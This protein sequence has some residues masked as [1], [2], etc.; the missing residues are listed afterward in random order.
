[1]WAVLYSTTDTDREGSTQLCQV[2]LLVA[3]GRDL[4]QGPQS[5][6]PGSGQA[7]ILAQAGAGG[8]LERDK[9]CFLVT[10]IC[11]LVRSTDKRWT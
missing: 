9:A 8:R 11:A 6:E 4:T 5:R 1:M 3:L 7:V 2:G 10:T